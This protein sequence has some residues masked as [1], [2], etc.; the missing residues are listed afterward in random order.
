MFNFDLC[1]PFI[2]NL[3]KFLVRAFIHCFFSAFF[4][5]PFV[6]RVTHKVLF[7][8][9]TKG[10]VLVINLMDHAGKEVRMVAWNEKIDRHINKFMV[11][12]VFY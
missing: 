1:I 8:T 4:S 3:S 5:N 9:H 11:S 10:K 2:L 12:N 7:V 6:C